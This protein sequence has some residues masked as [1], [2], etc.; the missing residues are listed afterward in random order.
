MLD[1]IPGME[2]FTKNPIVEEATGEEVRGRGLVVEGASF[3]ARDGHS[4]CLL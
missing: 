1:A 4:S 3:H 2:T